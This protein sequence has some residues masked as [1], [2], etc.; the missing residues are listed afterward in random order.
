M[1][2]LHK[3][4]IPLLIA[5]VVFAY[6]TTYYNSQETVTIEV[7]DKERIGL[8]DNEYKYL[9]YSEN[10]VFENTDTIFYLKYRSSDLQ[11]DLEEGQTFTVKVVGWRVP[12]LS[13]HRNIISIKE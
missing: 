9:V 13:W 10:E 1:K 8:N 7:V 3:I 12:F 5:I 2:Q 6:P 4:A 11:R